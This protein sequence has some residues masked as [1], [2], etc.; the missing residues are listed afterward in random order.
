MFKNTKLNEL[1]ISLNKEE[2][3]GFRKFLKSPYY[4]HRKD[5]P[6]LFEYILKLQKNKN[7]DPDLQTVYRSVYPTEPYDYDK[8]RLSMT[9]LLKLTEKYLLI[10]DRETA[11]TENMRLTKIYR[12]RNL[13]KHL[14]SQLKR[15][16]K[17]QSK[18]QLM[19]AD[20]YRSEYSFAVEKYNFAGLNRRSAAPALKEVGQSL[21]VVYLSQ[22]L[23]YACLVLAQQAVQ[24]TNYNVRLLDEVLRL[25]S[26]PEF[27]EIPAVSVYYHCYKALSENPNSG[28][29]ERFRLKLDKHSDLFPQEELGEL[30]LL[31]LNFCIRQYNA[32][33]KAYL[34]E[35]YQLYFESLEG[36]FLYKHGNL[37]RFTYRNIMTVCLALKKLDRAEQFNTQYKEKISSQ[38]RES[39]Y[40]FN[41]AR[42]EYRRK[43]YKEAL[44][45]LQKSEFEELFVN[46]AAKI[47]MLKIFYESGEWDVFFSHLQ[48]LKNFIYRQKDLGYHKENYLNFLRY[49]GKLTELVS[50]RRE[51]KEHLADKIRTESR[52]AEREWLLGVIFP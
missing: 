3:R 11:F 52:I 27:A 21:D 25:A 48:N 45:L 29:F 10:S 47:V 36:G 34:E 22:K 2:I 24:P 32:G 51:E 23:K 6:K 37:S 33:N 16:E 43:N 44:F 35:E 4:N 28:W 9:L 20:F 50:M 30:Y 14:S 12:K 26:T 41:A 8:L 1:I 49:A 39:S 18:E 40:S 13:A 42:L 15:T 17:E 38:Y 19:N 5:L 31:A 46:V 7:K